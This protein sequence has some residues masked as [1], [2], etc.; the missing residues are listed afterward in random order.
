M[1]AVLARLPE[2]MNALVVEFAIPD[3]DLW[4]R[5]GLRRPQGGARAARGPRDRRGPGGSKR[6]EGRGAEVEG[7]DAALSASA[8]NEEDCWSCI[9]NT[10]RPAPW[11]WQR[12]PSLV[13][14]RE[15]TMSCRPVG[16]VRREHVVLP[17][18]GEQGRAGRL[19]ADHA[20]VEPHVEQEPVGLA[21]QRA[22]LDAED[23]LDLVAVELRPDL[24]ELLLLGEPGDALLQV[25]VGAPRR[26][27][28]ALVAGGAVGPGELVQ[29]VEQVVGPGRSSWLREE[30]PT[31]D[32]N[33][34]VGAGVSRETTAPIASRICAIADH[35]RRWLGPPRPEVDG[36]TAPPISVDSEVP[37]SCGYPALCR[38]RL[39]VG[40]TTVR[41]WTMRSASK[42]GWRRAWTL[43]SSGRTRM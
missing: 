14:D 20:P 37:S 6:Y 7:R 34:G 31:A 23:L 40:V 24:G 30:R 15:C 39:G 4:H 38:R 42:I 8:C 28:L 19:L 32:G 36:L 17:R 1:R 2:A 12:W 26:L 35:S 33:G 18:P 27:R 41:A 21:H 9:E 3:R 25:V 16:G 10:V 13:G 5:C 29:P 11:S 22:G 43:P